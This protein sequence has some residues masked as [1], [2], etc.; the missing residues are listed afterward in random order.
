MASVEEGGR[1]GDEGRWM[2]HEAMEEVETGWMTEIERL[3]SEVA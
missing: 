2:V 3:V 1:M